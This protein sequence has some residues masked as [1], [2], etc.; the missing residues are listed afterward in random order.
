M[1]VVGDPLTDERVCAFF[2]FFRGDRIA[3]VVFPHAC[4]LKVTLRCSF[5]SKV[6]FLDHAFAVRVAWNDAD[7]DS[8]EV[9]ATECKS[10]HGDNC[11]RH[12]RVASVCLVDPVTQCP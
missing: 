9:K 8:M 4:N 3:E 2:P 6:K 7:L 11:L 10:Q 12:I 5:V 1:Q